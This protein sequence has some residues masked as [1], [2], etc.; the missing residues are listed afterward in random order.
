MP[1]RNPSKDTNRPAGGIPLSAEW[2]WQANAKVKNY[3]T[4]GDTCLYWFKEQLIPALEAMY[5]KEDHPDLKGFV[6][7]LDNAPYHWE[8]GF[9]TAG[10]SKKKM[11][12]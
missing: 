2:V 6:H 8:G 12:E 9:S 3:F 1:M 11:K 10:L 5:P 4:N 7:V